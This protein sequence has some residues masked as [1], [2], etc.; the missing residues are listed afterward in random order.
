MSQLSFSF[1]I[2]PFVLY[3]KNSQATF[4][5]SKVNQLKLFVSLKG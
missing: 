2:V 4:P 5:N 3:K 1:T